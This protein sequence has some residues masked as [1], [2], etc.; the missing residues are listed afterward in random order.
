MLTGIK[1]DE[2]RFSFEGES[3]LKASEELFLLSKEK[4]SYFTEGR[5]THEEDWLYTLK[6]IVKSF[7]N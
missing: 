6:L 5:V 4:Y 1:N 7:S 2:V 3:F